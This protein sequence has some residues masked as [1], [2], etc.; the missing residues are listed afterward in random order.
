MKAYQKESFQR[1][2]QTQSCLQSAHEEE[3][4]QWRTLLRT[5]ELVKKNESVAIKNQDR[6]GL[7]ETSRYLC[8]VVG[9]CKVLGRM[10]ID[11]R[12]NKGCCM[13]GSN[14]KGKS[15]DSRRNMM[16]FGLCW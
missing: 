6:R 16:A 5:S 14:N 15:S 1:R 3:E 13:G 7:T 11:R 10:L 8:V 4:A 2:H 12:R 9:T